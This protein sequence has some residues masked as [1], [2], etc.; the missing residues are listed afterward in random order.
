MPVTLRSLFLASVGAA[1]L[2]C[3]A[4]A[5][6]TAA[7]ADDSVF[8]LGDITLTVDDVAGYRADGAQATKSSVPLAE[9]QQSISVVTQDQIAEQGSDNLGETLNYSAGVLGQPFGADPRFNNPTLR[10]FSGER[11]Q[12]VNGLRQGRLFGAVDYE[13]YGM[14]QVEVLRGP[15]SSLYGSGS[16]AGI[17]NQVQK[18][19]RSTDFGEIGLGLDSDKGRQLFFDVNRAPTADLSWRVTG[20]GRDIRTQVD[21]V[22]NRRGFLAGAV[23]WTPDDATTID[24]LSSYTRDSPITPVGVPYALAQSGD[25]DDLRDLNAGEPGFDDSD[26]RL[27]TLGAEVSHA[28]D[29]GWTLS[30]GVRYED[31]DWTYDA[32]SCAFFCP[33]NADGTFN[34]TT[35]RQREDSQTLSADTRLS[36]EI[37]TGAA[38]HQVLL[39]LDVQKYESDDFTI[40]GTA[41][42]LDPSNPVRD[43]D[44]VTM[45]GF[46]GGRDISFTQ[47][48]L[49]AQDQMSLGNW[50]G[51][52][53]LRYDMAEQDGLSYGSDSSFDDSE[54][55][56]RAGL[57]YAFANGLLP[58]VSYA[59]SFEPLPGTDIQGSALR[60]TQGKQWEAGL[61]YSPAAF[62]GLFTAALYDLRQ[63]NLTR[64][65]SEEIGGTIVSGLRQIGEA[66]SRGLE[67]SAIATVAQGWDVQAS[68]AYNDTEQREGDNAGKALPNAPKHLASL[69]VMRDFGNGIRAG[70]GIRHVGERFGDEA[71]TLDLDSQTLLDLGATYERG[72]IK[73]ALNVQNLTDRAYVATCSSFGCFFGQGRTVTAKVSYQW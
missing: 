36:G 21:D 40:F 19:A 5:Q 60:P 43:P 1:A 17:V 53:G 33:L 73:A 34:R 6:D 26:R 41:S 56:G 38:T 45:D 9:A 12:Y 68:Y 65:V 23:R 48:G 42:P 30:Q 20:A 13:T 10:G 67:L 18:R 70:G 52:L 44:A 37:T 31:F 29:N 64:P 25:L 49:Y 54:L 50:R 66:K 59:T 7:T 62:D 15:S 63:T 71:N 58:Y 61:K 46:R 3:P 72:N 8:V 47:T 57:A 2:A 35:I 11:A 27:F 24:I 4:L 39:G 28:L 55:T 69:W 14:Q 22:D 51:S 16:P 32:T